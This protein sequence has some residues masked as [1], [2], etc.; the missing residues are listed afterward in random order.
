MT[1]HY[2]NR[3]KYPIQTCVCKY[4]DEKIK[5]KIKIIIIQHPDEQN[6]SK[7]TA[8]LLELKLDNV[9]IIDSSNK[10]EMEFIRRNIDNKWLMLFPSS[11]SKDVNELH[12]DKFTHLIVLDGTWKKVKKII[13]LNDWLNTISKVSFNTL[14]NNQYTIRKAEEKYSLSTLESVNLF[15]SQYEKTPS[16]PLLDLL[17]GLIKEQTKYMPKNVKR[18]Y[19]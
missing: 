18:R 8:R 14:P 7:N 13:Y 2:C 1:R 3:C 16:Q 17:N 12:R 11:S 15:L 19:E 10:L 4:V 6:L 5:N 9:S